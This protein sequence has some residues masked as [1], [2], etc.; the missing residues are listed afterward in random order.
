MTIPTN[1]QLRASQQPRLPAAPVEYDQNFMD[2]SFS[3]LRQYFNQVDNIT[4]S[5]LTNVGQRFFRAPTISVFDTT[6]QSAAANTVTLVTYNNVDFSNAIALDNTGGGATNS[7]FTIT[8]PGIYNVQFSAQ[9]SNSASAADNITLWF[10]VNGTD[11]TNT[12]GIT[13]VPAKHGS[14]NGATVFG[15]NQFLSLTANDYVQ[16]YWTTDGGTSS[17]TTYAASGTPPVHPASPS[18]AVTFLFVSAPL[19]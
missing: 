3:I 11:V 4:Q 15:W 6:T 10:R 17:L 9:G 19:S 13:A 1:T 12:A 16:I 7:K 2:S 18:I 5:I 14:I 8:Y